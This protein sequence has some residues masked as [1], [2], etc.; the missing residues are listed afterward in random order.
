MVELG[1][2]TWGASTGSGAGSESQ[3][4][5]YRSQVRFGIFVLLLVP[6]I[7]CAALVCAA[8]LGIIYATRSDALWATH[9]QR[10][11]DAVPFE[12]LDDSST[13]TLRRTMCFGRCPA[14][15]LKIFGSGR[16][17]YV[18]RNYVCAFGA[19]TAGAD[20]R[21]V[22][23]LV[24]AMIATGYLGYAWNPGVLWTDSPTAITSLSHRGQSFEISH[25]HGDRGAPEWLHAMEEE[26]DRVAGAA[27]WL[28]THDKNWQAQCMSPDGQ[29]RDVTV[30]EPP[31]EPR[32]DALR[33]I[34]PAIEVPRILPIAVPVF[35]RL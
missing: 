10:A 26:I 14:Y 31:P 8:N 34:E 22:S 6:W 23:R 28:P 20:A 5:P 11:F 1:P 2:N 3:N 29:L 19:Q 16:V 21:E 7:I 24:Q 13:I 18:G 4:P 27:R 30:G 25:Y 9:S 17:E 33:S 32:P 12:T 15:D 35:S